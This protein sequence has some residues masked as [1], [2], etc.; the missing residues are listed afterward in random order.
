MGFIRLL[1]ALLIIVALA[2]GVLF[3]I[4]RFSDGPLELVAGGPFTTGDI[5]RGPEPDWSFVADR[6]TIQF[7][8]VDPP[9]S[10]TAWIIEYDGR[11]FIPC[12]YMDTFWGRLWKQWPIEAERDGRAL[13]RID[14]TIYPRQLV[15]V[16]SG[17][18][19]APVVAKLAQKYGMPVDV[20]A[21]E[22]GSLW[23]FQAAPPGS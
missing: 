10:R 13:L 14:G 20:S 11:I 19:V 18:D 9:R 23:L 4:A 22:S 12:G 7:Q 21:V 16:Q 5:Y 15:R 17:P 1:G 2:L 6:P 8:L 3:I